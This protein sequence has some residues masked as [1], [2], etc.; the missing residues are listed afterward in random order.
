MVLEG[1]APGADGSTPRAP[2]HGLDID[3]DGVRQ[4]WETSDDGG[5]TWQT[6]FDR[7]TAAAKGYPVR[8]A[9]KSR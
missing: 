1:T 2:T 3:Q 8:P 9:D 6:A 7:G 4:H 5:A